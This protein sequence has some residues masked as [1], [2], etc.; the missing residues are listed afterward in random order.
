LEELYL[1]LP[2][3]DA[4][5]SG[6]WAGASNGNGDGR[7][8]GQDGVRSGHGNGRSKKAVAEIRRRTSL[9]STGSE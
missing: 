9:G 4:G 2:G 5:A 8:D 6:R 7:I 3:D 1:A